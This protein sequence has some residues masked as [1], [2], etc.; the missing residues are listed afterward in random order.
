MKLEECE[1][2]IRRITAQC[3]ELQD[4]NNR[5]LIENG[6]LTDTVSALEMSLAEVKRH[7]AKELD[8]LAPRVQEVESRTEALVGKVEKNTLDVDLMAGLV[9]CHVHPAQRLTIHL[10]GPEA[11]KDSNRSL[12]ADQDEG[13]D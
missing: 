13:Q 7:A 2:I 6:R 10:I 12:N 9:R 8:F 3:E 11:F 1:V 4:E 5:I